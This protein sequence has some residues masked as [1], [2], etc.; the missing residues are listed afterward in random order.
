VAD[1]SIDQATGRLTSNQEWGMCS[2]ITIYDHKDHVEFRKDHVEFR[3]CPEQ[4]AF[5]MNENTLK[6]EP[7]GI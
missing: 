5:P 7:S 2:K 3:K 4:T 1:C 6:L